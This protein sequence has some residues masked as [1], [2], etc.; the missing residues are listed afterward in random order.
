MDP[1]TQQA[2]LATA[3]AA[4][5]DKVYVDDVF[6][7][8]LY[9]GTSA[10]QT[11]TNGIDLAGEGGLVWIKVRSAQGGSVLTDTERGTDKLIYS[12]STSA[13]ASGTWGVNAF[14]ANGF[15]VTGGDSLNNSSGKTYA[16]WAFRKAPGFFDVVEYTGNDTTGRTVPHNLGSVPGMILIKGTDDT[17][18]WYVYHRELGSN[19]YIRLNLSNGASTNAAIFGANPTST[20]F[21]VGANWGNN[22][23]GYNFVAYVFAHDDQSF[24]T[25]GDESIIKC[26]SYTGTGL[27]GN[28][29]DV[30]FEPQFVITKNSTSA[31]EWFMYDSM[32]IDANGDQKRLNPSTA[33]A[34]LTTTDPGMKFNATGFTPIQNN[35][36]KSGQTF[37]YMA[38]RRPHKPP[39]VGTDVF[40]VISRSG[41][42]STTTVNSNMG[43]VDMWLTKSTGD[44]TASV[45]GARMIGSNTLTT[46]STAAENTNVFGSSSPWDVQEGINLTSDGDTNA[47]FRT[48]INYF[49][50]RAPGFFDVVAY[51]GTGGTQNVSHNLTVAPEFLIHKTRSNS[52]EWWCWHS[53]LGGV[54]KY[55]WLDSISAAVSSTGIWGSGVTSSQFT[56]ESG[57]A[58]AGRTFITYLF[59]TLPGISKIG[60]YISDGNA[61]DV[62]CGF[63]TGARFV[64]IKKSSGSGNW[65]VFDTV[66]GIT[67][68]NDPYIYLNDTI[69]NQTTDD[70]IDPLNAGFALPASTPVN[71]SG[72]TYIFLAIA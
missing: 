44:T 34:E 38:I 50:K 58:T 14:N 72:S 36:N 5:G 33:N 1:I 21:T 31:N 68:G 66:R 65:Y 19:D 8:D 37:I 59:A 7:T 11:I 69:A 64:L 16:S 22:R 27:S 24:G 15:T 6:S 2:V 48:Y 9:D 67:S 61:R 47:S 29:I 23:D 42:G 56:V 17:Y 41:S 4:G 28:D 60:S 70:Y 71:T 10:T 43:P 3:G 46:S 35:N 52:F 45:L 18:D 62:D 39:T 53:G 40:S 55:I 51:T 54:D 26:G 63:T 13:E 49:F 12:N 20:H 32:R 57:L 25:D 30:G